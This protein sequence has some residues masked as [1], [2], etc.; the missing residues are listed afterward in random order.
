MGDYGKE[1]K[2]VIGKNFG[3]EGKGKC[4]DLLC[5]EA[6]EEGKKAVV[7]RHNGGAQA[8]HT[9]EGK[10][11]RFVFHQL[12]SGCF[13]ETPF[14]WSETFLPDLVKLGEEAEAFE[15]IRGDN[16]AGHDAVAVYASP[17]CVCV[18]VFDV[19][20]N[21]L[22]EELRREARHG[23]CGM[24]IYE[25]VRRARSVTGGAVTFRLGD[26]EGKSTEEIAGMLKRI[27]DC[28]V[29]GRLEEI[30][31]ELE[32]GPGAPFDRDRLWEY[33]WFRLLRDDNV[34]WNAS[35]LMRENFNRYVITAGPSQVLEPF[36]TVI[37][38]GAQGLL[39]DEDNTEYYPHLTPS[40]TGLFNVSR[41]LA[42]ARIEP[43]SLDVRYVT[44][45]YVTR[46]GGGRLDHECRKEEINPFMQDL[47]NLPNPWQGELRFAKHPDVS[48]FFA[49]LEMDLGNLPAWLKKCLCARIEVTHL[50]ETDGRIL[51]CGRPREL[52]EFQK[53]CKDMGKEVLCFK[54]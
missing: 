49:P 54:I 36:D 41:L 19:L 16:G 15:R 28:Y 32:G 25:T 38:E 52:E 33:E 37:C 8:G 43:V 11:F 50:D 42:S 21:S 20:L 27:R 35:D 7:V 2:A 12:G 45:S 29:P 44:R 26:L 10:N 39:L 9:V 13:R 30:C 23:S 18:T 17:D 6:M 46:H 24:G 1:I 3:D 5:A 4:V 48:G 53:E 51:C 22:A 47:T 14:Y 31:R 34:L 40:H